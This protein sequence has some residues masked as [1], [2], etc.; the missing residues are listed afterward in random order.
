MS[1]YRKYFAKMIHQ[2][3]PNGPDDIITAVDNH[4]KQISS[5]VRFATASKNPI[6]KRLDFCSYFLALIKTLDEQGASFEAIRKICLEITTE[7]VRPKNK[8]QQ[9]LRQLPVKLANTRLA[10]IY[11]KE[12]NKRVS[13][14]ANP[15]GFVANIITDK[16]ETFG[17]GYGIDIVECGICK[18]FKKHGYQK[19]A[20]ILCEVDAVTSSLAGLKLVRNGTIA[21]G[22]KKCDFRF[23]KIS[24]T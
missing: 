19:Y 7:Y 15:N 16:R 11:L 20:S 13:R 9:V 21:L 4:Y 23:Q 1:S 24:D 17:F 8:I 10:N 14:N 6:D 22:A 5:D 18:L 3:Y 12:L 2:R